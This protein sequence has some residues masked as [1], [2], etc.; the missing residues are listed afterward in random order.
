M[1]YPHTSALRLYDA[2]VTCAGGDASE[3]RDIQDI[4][5]EGDT[6]RVHDSSA[7]C[8]PHSPTPRQMVDHSGRSYFQTHVNN[9]FQKH[10]S[11]NGK[12]GKL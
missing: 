11:D 8:P 3:G 9:S 7:E 5:L 1:T 10:R 6:R 12:T 2:T 4:H